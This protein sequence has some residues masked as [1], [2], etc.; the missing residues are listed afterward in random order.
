ML[1]DVFGNLLQILIIVAVRVV[2]KGHAETVFLRIARNQVNMRMENGLICE[3]TVIVD[4][5]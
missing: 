4:D 2:F 5:V 1:L 3:L